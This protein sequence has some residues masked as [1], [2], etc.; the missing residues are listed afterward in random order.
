MKLFRLI[1]C[2]RTLGF[3]IGYRYW[4]IE[5]NSRVHPWLALD[6][7]EACE[8]EANKLDKKGEGLLA[9]QHRAWAKELRES[10]SRFMGAKQ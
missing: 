9:N 7:A 8:D 2:I 10:Y 6:W 4:K 1:H 3:D 5:N